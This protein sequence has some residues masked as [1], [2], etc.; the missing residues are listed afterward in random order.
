M[1]CLNHASAALCRPVLRVM[2]FA[3]VQ[4]VPAPFHLLAECNSTLSISAF[5]PLQIA[6]AM[7]HDQTNAKEECIGVRRCA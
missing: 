2:P 1:F 5:A 7:S 3:L 6:Y 4:M